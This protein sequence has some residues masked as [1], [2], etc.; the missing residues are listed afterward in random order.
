M[1]ERAEICHQL[2]GSVAAQGEQLLG[3][4]VLGDHLDGHRVSGVDIALARR[5]EHVLD[6]AD[7]LPHRQRLGRHVLL[8]L[9][10]DLV[11]QQRLDQRS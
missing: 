3:D 11:V 10:V 8:V 4:A 2:G 7:R 1:T 9:E 6:D 5:R